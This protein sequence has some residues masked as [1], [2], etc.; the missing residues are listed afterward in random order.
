MTAEQITTI[1]TNLLTSGGVATFFFFVVR[2]LKQEISGLNKT[3]EAQNKTLEVMEKRITET[4]RVGDIYKGLITELPE[5]IEQY[6]KIIQSTKD[7]VITELE[8]ANQAK[9]EKLK[10]TRE[11]ELRRL[12]LQEELLAE[13]PKLREELLSTTNAIQNRV[14]ALQP[15]RKNPFVLVGH[16][17]LG[18]TRPL[19]NIINEYR[20]WLTN[21]TKDYATIDAEYVDVDAEPDKETEKE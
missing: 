8:H 10:E 18:T 15:S 14:E 6:K 16:H 12:E 17:G 3:I 21:A 20:L 19:E 13:L 1:I 7:S 11:L 4:E 9:D 5:Y 2:S